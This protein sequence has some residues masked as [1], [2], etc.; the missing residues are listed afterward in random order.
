MS[1]VLQVL[2]RFLGIR[3][4]KLNKLGYNMMLSENT[5]RDNN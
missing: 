5:K 3:L 4:H 1:S 2:L